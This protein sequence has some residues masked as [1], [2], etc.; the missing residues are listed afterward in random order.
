MIWAAGELNPEMGEMDIKRDVP[1]STAKAEF[2]KML[3][4]IMK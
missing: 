1:F 4:I 3:M 2:S